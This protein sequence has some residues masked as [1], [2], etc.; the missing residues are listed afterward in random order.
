MYSAQDAVPDGIKVDIERRLLN[1]D[2]NIKTAG[3]DQG[4]DNFEGGP[5][6]DSA[7]GYE[8]S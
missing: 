7:T 1:N 4:I 8:R 3:G 5:D 6:V 2:F